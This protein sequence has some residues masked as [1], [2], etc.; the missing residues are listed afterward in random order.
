MAEN[1]NMD[2]F[3]QDTLRSIQRPRDVDFYS[4]QQPL[5]SKSTKQFTTSSISDTPVS[6]FT[7]GRLLSQASSS[8]FFGTYNATEDTL[9]IGKGSYEYPLGTSVDVEETTGSGY[10]AYAVIKQSAEGG[11]VSFEIEI[12]NDP[13]D[14]TTMAA[15]NSF[16]EYSNVLLGEV[17]S[18]PSEGDGANV[19]KF[20]QRRVGNLSLIYRIINGAFCLWPETTG[21]SPM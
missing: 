7:D 15:G 19:T 1:V 3:I 20:V 8:S 11:L 5:V 12:S 6:V 9:T 13:K 2:S 17:K 4:E 21:G 18:V 16:L 14:P 10:F